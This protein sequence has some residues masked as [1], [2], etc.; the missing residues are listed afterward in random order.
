MGRQLSGC[1]EVGQVC[2]LAVCHFTD[3]ETSVCTLCLTPH[4]I[5]LAIFMFGVL[6]G[7][8]APSILYPFKTLLGCDFFSSALPGNEHLSTFRF[9]QFVEIS[10]MMKTPFLFFSLL[11]DQTF[12]LFLYC[13]FKGWQAGEEGKH[14]CSVLQFTPE[15]QS[16]YF[17]TF[18]DYGL[19]QI[20]KT[21]VIKPNIY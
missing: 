17:N 3:L 10:C 4:S 20:R 6:P 16:H 19:M 8:W 15:T 1:G 14:M 5:L 2:V 9:P 12:F 18:D 21:Q 11:W 7:R 13:N